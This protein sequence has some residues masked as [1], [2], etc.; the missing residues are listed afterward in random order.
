MKY[1]HI[2]GILLCCMLVVGSG[3]AVA[4]PLSGQ[5][6]IQPTSSQDVRDLCSALVG[7]PLPTD[8][9]TVKKHILTAVLSPLASQV[10][11]INFTITHGNL[12]KRRTINAL[13]NRP[14]NHF[15]HPNKALFVRNMDF[16]IEFTIKNT[17]LV[18]FYRFMFC[19]MLMTRT[20]NNSEMFWT[21]NHVIS[22]TGFTGM[23][24]F[25]KFDPARLMPAHFM[26]YGLCEQASILPT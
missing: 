10:V 16:T 2:I 24:K 13:I 1:Q 14:I 15:I 20:G 8:Q 26:F 22:V 12:F 25:Y 3:S 21:Q 11:A 7:S 19:S 23:F 6:M 18:K 9:T 4:I 5:H 17:A